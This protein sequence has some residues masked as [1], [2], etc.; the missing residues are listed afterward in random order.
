MIPYLTVP[1]KL[2]SA[3]RTG[4]SHTAKWSGMRMLWQITLWQYRSGLCCETSCKC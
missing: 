2:P 4:V 1:T 3:C